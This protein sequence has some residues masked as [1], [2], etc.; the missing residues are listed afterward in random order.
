VYLI[1]RIQESK[2]LKIIFENFNKM[3]DGSNFDKSCHLEN[4][5]QNFFQIWKILNFLKENF[6]FS[7]KKVKNLS[8]LVWV[9]GRKLK[10][11]MN[12]RCLLTNEIGYSNLEFFEIGL[13]VF[14]KNSEIFLKNG[15][16]FV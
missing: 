16:K 15:Q 8:K 5:I 13:R 11:S 12:M 7:L 6:E 2:N 10:I 9:A 1:L 4:S 3:L 14:L